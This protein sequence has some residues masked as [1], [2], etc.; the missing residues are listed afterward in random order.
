M[1]KFAVALIAG[2]FALV[3]GFASG[4]LLTRP[5]NLVMEKIVNEKKA[6]QKEFE[7][8]QQQNSVLREVNGKLKEESERLSN[9]LLSTF[10]DEHNRQK[11]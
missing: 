11:I 6:L 9:A 3:I 7:S 1:P 8:V 4:A 10:Q 2:A 5:D